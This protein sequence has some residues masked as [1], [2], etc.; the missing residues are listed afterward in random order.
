MIF[1]LTDDGTN[2]YKTNNWTGEQK[3][4]NIDRNEA[5]TFGWLD[6]INAGAGFG[7]GENGQGD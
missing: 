3:P 6:R 7:V 5:A 1:V 2:T 4:E